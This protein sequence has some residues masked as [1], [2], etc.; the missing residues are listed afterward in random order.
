MNWIAIT[1]TIVAFVGIGY[2]FH[3]AM[4]P[5]RTDMVNFDIDRMIKA[6]DG[7]FVKL[8]HDVDENGF[9]DWMA[10]QAKINRERRP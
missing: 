7:P 4:R 2:F 3:F 9:H 1:L 5:S 8:P 6:L 10:K